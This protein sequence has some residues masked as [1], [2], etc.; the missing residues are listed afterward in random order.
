MWRKRFNLDP[1][2][3]GRTFTLN[4]TARTLVGIMPPRFTKMG[5]DLWMP[6]VPNRAD[7]EAKQHYFMF[8][9][10]LKPGVTFRDAQA[11]IDVLAHHLAQVYPKDYPK[12]FTVEVVSWV[13]WLVRRV[14]ADAVHAGGGRQSAAADRVQQ[15]GE[16][17]AGAGHGPGEGNGDSRFARRDQVEIDP[18]IA[19][20]KSPAGGGRRGCRLPALVRRDQ[21]S[22]DGDSGW[23]DT[24][25]SG[26]QSERAGAA[27]QSGSRGIH[28][29]VV[30]TG[31]GAANGQAGCRRAAQGFRQRRQRRI[32]SRQAAECAGAGRSGFVAGSADGRRSADAQ[33]RGID[34]GRPGVESGQRTGGAPAF[35]AR[36]IQDCRSQ[37]AILP[38]T[39]AALVMHCRE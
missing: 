8:Q 35:S 6:M 31:A 15:R 3:L 7:P 34:A 39:V 16:H 12:K 22:G 33:F 13:D 11:D 10:H 14:P 36:A 25:R 19:D 28:G 26:D 17:A 21:G 30:R 18:A 38:S 24:A 1:A 32:S 5:A 37:A 29:I 9:G 2:M 27:V 20:G 23:R 4:G